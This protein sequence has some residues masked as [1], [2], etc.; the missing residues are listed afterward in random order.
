MLQ[1]F[2]FMAQVHKHESFSLD[3]MIAIRVIS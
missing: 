3:L 2:L 1:G